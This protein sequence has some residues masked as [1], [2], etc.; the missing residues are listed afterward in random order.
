MKRLRWILGVVASLALI[1]ALL[2]TSFEVAVYSDFDWYQKEYEKYN[3]TNDLTMKL[4]DVMDVTHEMMAY[5]RGNRED[6]VVYTTIGGVENQEF[7]NDQDKT[8]MAD[9]QKL[10]LG[11]L[12][13]RLIALGL[14]VLCLGVMIVTKVDLKRLLPRCYQLGLGFAAIGTLAVGIYAALDFNTFFTKFHEVF[15]TNDLWIFDPRSDYMI[16]MLPEGFFADMA[17]RIG[18]MFVISLLIVLI[19]SIIYDKIYRKKKIT[20]SEVRG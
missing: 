14:L 9:V 12:K 8:H 3:V 5:L 18:M 6:L 15:F 4:D 13:L 17:F 20:I 2:I 16:R 7:F 10:F 1:F 11:G 19:I